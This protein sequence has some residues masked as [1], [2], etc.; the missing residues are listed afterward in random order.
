MIPRLL[1]AQTVGTWLQHADWLHGC[2][3]CLQFF[4]RLPLIVK[5]QGF[6]ACLLYLPWPTALTMCVDKA[7][8]GRAERK[9]TQGAINELKN[10][11]PGHDFGFF[12]RAP[13]GLPFSECPLL[14]F[15]GYT[16]KGLW[17]QRFWAIVDALAQV[18]GLLACYHSENIPSSEACWSGVEWSLAQGFNK[19]PGLC[20]MVWGCSSGSI[21]DW[22]LR[23]ALLSPCAW[24]LDPS[25]RTAKWR[26]WALNLELFLL[27][28]RV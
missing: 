6:W 23:L 5:G 19:V 21:Q 8:R 27:E 7:A 24:S 18:W 22:A 4:V 9:L 1:P 20:W 12:I 15:E 25:E 13:V 3:S 10:R 11:R 14:Y 17:L 28:G 16:K 26:L 2:L